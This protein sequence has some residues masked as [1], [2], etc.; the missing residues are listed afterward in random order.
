MKTAI[1]TGASSGLGREFA[2]Q[3]PKFYRS[4]DEIWLIARSSDK[5]EQLKEELT[6]ETG[7]YCRIYDSDLTRDY[8][9]YHLQRDL[10]ALRP[11]IR[12]VVNAAGIGCNAPVMQAEAD[13]LI[14]MIQLNCTALTH[15]TSLCLPYMNRG[16]R[17]VNLASAAAFAPQ[18]R[19]AVYGATK[20][21]VLSFSRALGR[22]LADRMIFV[23]A[24]CSGPVETN[25]F[26]TA[27]EPAGKTRQKLMTQPGKVVRKA[28]TDVRKRRSISVYGVA[29]KGART[30][31][32]IAPDR[33]TDWFMNKMNTRSLT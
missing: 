27:G 14:G 2:R 17:I 4:L 7:I 29:M 8:I 1:V 30:V 21:Y 33:L 25:F 13:A 28:L 32:K 15:L 5:L 24:I 31:A 26:R 19:S 20:A 6:K 22:E 16:S 3:I 11:D 9:Y 18:P 10:E 23:T 12:M